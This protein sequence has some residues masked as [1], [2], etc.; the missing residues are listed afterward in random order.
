MKP[1]LRWSAA[2]GVDSRLLWAW[3]GMWLLA[4][5]SLGWT[6]WGWTAWGWIAWGHLPSE[7]WRWLALGAAGLLAVGWVWRPDPFFAAGDLVIHGGRVRWRDQEGAL[8]WVWLGDNLLGLLCQPNEGKP[9]AVWL[10]RRRVGAVAWWQL[11]RALALH[12][13]DARGAAQRVKPRSK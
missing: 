6:A 13:P 5:I 11:R 2:L 3:R 4:A 12:P 7:G 10:T 9:V 8:V 1:G